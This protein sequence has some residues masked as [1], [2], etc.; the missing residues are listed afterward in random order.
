MTSKYIT[1][2]LAIV[3]FFAVIN[4]IS[5]NNVINFYYSNDA[6]GGSYTIAGVSLGVDGIIAIIIGCVVIGAASGFHL[7]GSGLSDYSQ[8]IIYKT[9]LYY[10]IW[11]VFSALGIG[12]IYTIPYIGFLF[13]LLLTLFYSIGF[14]E[15]IGSH[16][17]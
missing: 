5:T 7:F 10:S 13:W 16:P 14:Q 15:Q 1:I 8:A 17:S 12:L 6:S 11:G 3:I 2:P 9:L 4:F